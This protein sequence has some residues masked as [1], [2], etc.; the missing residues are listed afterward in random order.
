MFFLGLLLMVSCGNSKAPQEQESE[1]PAEDI[2]WPRQ[3]QSDNTTLVYYQPQVDKWDNYKKLEGRLAFSI[4]PNGGNEVLGVV[5]FVCDTK[6]DKDSHTTYLHDIKYTDVR[7]PS[8]DAGKAATMKETFLQMM[9]TGAETISTDRIL[10]Y[11]DGK[12]DAAAPKGVTLKNDPPKIFYSAS[13]AILLFVDGDPVLS[14]IERTNLQFIV[15]TNWDVFFDKQGG[16]YYMLADDVWLTTKTLNGHW[17]TTAFL[18]EEFSSLPTGQNFDEV[19]Q[20]IPPQSENG[21]PTVFYTNVPAELIATEGAPVY[22]KIPGTRLLYVSN[23]DNDI[24]INEADGQYYILLSGRWFRAPKFGGPWAYAG[25]NLPD[26]FAKIPEDSPMAHVLA[27]VPGTQEASDAVLLAQIPTTVVVNKA[28]AEAKAHATYDGDPKFAPIE[29]TTMQYATNTQDKVIRVGD[30]YY[31]CFQA[32]WF[33]STSPEG[34]WKTAD[35]V[36]SV[37]YTIPPSSPVY[38]VTYVTQTNATSTTVE[39]SSTAGYL[40]A[41][42]IGATVGAIF[43]AAIVY[44]T[45]W[46][47]HP[48]VYW[49]PYAP[50]P[51]YRPW[52][53]TYGGGAVYNPWTG[54][55]AV[56]R[57]VYGPYGAAGSSAWYN[58]ATGHYGRS[59]SVQGWY[60]GRT[61]AN[62]YN[63]WTGTYGHTSQ[64]HN[65]YAQWGHSEV[66]NGNRWASSSHV[67]TAAG[68]AFTYHTSGGKSGVVVDGRH[69]VSV[70]TNGNRVYAG[71]DGNVYRKNE[72]GS[73][74]RYN[75]N[76]RQWEAHPSVG[77]PHATAPAHVTAPAHATAPA[78]VT[79]PVTAPAHRSVGLSN[80]SYGGSTQHY[81]NHAEQSRTRGEQQ[82]QRF[83]TARQ[84]GSL[85]GGLLRRSR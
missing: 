82:T 50:Y 15:N 3:V 43:D 22:S 47:Y 53:Y 38:N 54:G 44:G 84:E 8:L 68:T 40:G 29:G 41:F 80:P 37:I 27:S 24:F 46:Y 59:A 57:R 83:S 20:H 13:P 36:P 61:A 19:I 4:T 33:M 23:T 58:P 28:E 62:V 32:I 14:P 70:H 81:L 49:A 69:G 73:W 25:G 31:M 74:A 7:F 6:T 51:I 42:I 16:Q 35:S 78:H 12:G 10:A 63:P 60:G 52:P 30:L 26:D 79:T 45:G 56:G 67:T 5:S 17:T 2:G 72:N 9:P 76:N 85:H 11:L 65:P 1:A 34:P 21:A 66:S 39:S 48:Y 71:S 18:P 55:F 64:G 75:N 77:T